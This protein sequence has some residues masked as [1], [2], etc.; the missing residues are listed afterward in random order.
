M[1][2]YLQPLP[3]ESSRSSDRTNIAEPSSSPAI[4]IK[5]AVLPNP[6]SHDHGLLLCRY[7]DDE[8]LVWIP[9]HGEAV[10]HRSEFFF[11]TDWN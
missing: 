7:S 9:D 10:L 4:W 2:R 3:I 1:G 5:L 8:W 11:E 6:Y